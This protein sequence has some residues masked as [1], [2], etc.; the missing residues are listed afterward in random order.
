MEICTYFING[1]TFE[2]VC[3]P[4]VTSVKVFAV[5]TNSSFAA[6]ALVLIVFVGIGREGVHGEKKE[7][8]QEEIVSHQRFFPLFLFSLWTLLTISVALL[9]SLSHFLS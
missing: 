4:A 1:S 9:V 5:R 3:F 7:E 8:E 6:G 2:G